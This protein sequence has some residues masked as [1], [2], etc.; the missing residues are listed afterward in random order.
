MK[1]Y[2][3]CKKFFLWGDSMLLE[4][5][6][7]NAVCSELEKNGYIIMQRKKEIR[8][9][10]IDIIAKKQNSGVNERYFIEAVGGTSS[11]KR[12]KKFGEPFDSS[13]CRVHV[14]EQLYACAE[15]LS[16][17]KVEGITYRVGMAFDDNEYYRKYID[18]IKTILKKL[19]FE[20]LFVNDFREVS[21][22]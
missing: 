11:D 18:D 4:L 21:Y 1:E 10:G 22:L 12:S 19:N 16:R 6:V 2:N 5:D 15:L 9:N 8:H 7:I 13:Q 3:I 14:A 20:V 17:P